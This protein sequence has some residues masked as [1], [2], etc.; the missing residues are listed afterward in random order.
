MKTIRIATQLV[1]VAV[2]GCSIGVPASTFASNATTPLLYTSGVDANGYVDVQGYDARKPQNGPIQ[3]LRGLTASATGMA[4]DQQGNL[5]V[6]Q[7][8]PNEPAVIYK[9][10]KT[11]PSL[12]LLDP[13]QD[14]DQN[15]NPV[16]PPN[17][18]AVGSDGTVYVEM[19]CTGVTA[20]GILVQGGIFVY[21]KGKT[22][23]SA[24]L[25]ENYSVGSVKIPVNECS[26]RGLAVDGKGDVYVACNGIPIGRGQAFPIGRVLE[27]PAGSTRAVDTGIR[28]AGEWPNCTAQCF[29]VGTDDPQFS[30]GIL[31]LQ[32]DAKGNLV[33]LAGSTGEYGNAIF[34]YPPNVSRPSRV[35]PLNAYTQAAYADNRSRIRFDATMT[36]IFVNHVAQ[37]GVGIDEYTYP[38]GKR[39]ATFSKAMLGNAAF[40]VSPSP[41]FP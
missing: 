3:T 1:C 21:K 39:V 26:S 33:V 15:K 28:V 2:L 8:D 29:N 17:D 5:Y 32:L 30:G 41:V 9:P 31:D 11:T 35:I 40:A 7:S 16:G 20:D 27:F 12:T 38:A 24:F 23:P 22:T 4:V 18:I 10:G 37:T 34:V 19:C 6:S 25:T 14:K 36:H 13:L